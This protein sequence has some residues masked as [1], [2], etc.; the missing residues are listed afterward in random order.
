MYLSASSS[1]VYVR[2]TDGD[3]F[4]IVLYKRTTGE[5][6]KVVGLINASLATFDLTSSNDLTNSPCIR[7]VRILLQEFPSLRGRGGEVTVLIMNESELNSEYQN[8]GIGKSLYLKCM[9]E[10]WKDNGRKPFLFVP[11]YCM[12]GVTSNEAR[13]VW[14]S[15]ARRYPSSGDCIAVLEAP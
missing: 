15:L 10:G 6:S 14:T 7:D 13:R 8:Q 12:D 5:R 11:H 4:Y 3:H 1:L 2:E 9:G